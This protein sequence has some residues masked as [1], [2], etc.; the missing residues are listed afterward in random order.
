MPTDIVIR[1]ATESDCAAISALYAELDTYHRLRRPDLFRAVE[2]PARDDAFLKG[3]IAGPDS[4]IFVAENGSA[5]LGLSAIYARIL[6]ANAIR[7]ERRYAEIDSFG[8]TENARRLG[9]GKQ[10]MLAS[11]A[12]A[13]EKGM[14]KLELQVHGFNK[15]AIAFYEQDGFTPMMHRMERT[16]I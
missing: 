13:R 6:P 15:G 3:V 2:G 7:P 4:V 8:L 12:W 5:L 9:I 16:L 1:R 11:E 10:L 14:P